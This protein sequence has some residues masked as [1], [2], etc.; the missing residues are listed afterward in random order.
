[1]ANPGVREAW[2][3]PARWTWLL[4]ALGAAAFVFSFPGASIWPLA[5]VTPAA[6]SAAAVTARRTRTL[7]IAALVTL[8]IAWGW[9]ERWVLDVSTLGWFP[10]TVTMALMTTV[11]LLALRR[12]ACHPRLAGVPLALLV[13]LTWCAGESLRGL[14][15]FD[16]YPWYHVAHPLIAA[17]ILVQSTDLF[18]VPGVSCLVA[19]PGGALLD[20]LRFRRGTTN[21]AV[22]IGAA[23]ATA[24]LWAANLG[25]GAWRLG[26]SAPLS[27]GPT[28]LAVQTNLPMSNKIAWSLE[29]QVDDFTTFRRQT[30]DAFD[31]AM[32]SGRRPDLVA[33]PETMLPGFGL[34][35]E[36]VQMLVQ[37]NYAPGDFFS[38]LIV[39][40]AEMLETPFL[41]GSPVYTGLRPEGKRWRWSAHFNSAYLVEPTG[42]LQ[43]YDKLFL[44]PFGERMPYFSSWPWLEERL[45]AIGASGMTF[46]LDAGAE[47]R[48]LD[49]AWRDDSGAV[50]TTRLATPICFEDTVGWLCRELVYERGVKSA[51]V[52]VNLS[53]DGWFGHVDAGREAHL[54]MARFRT[55]ELRVPMVRVVN[56]GITASIDSCGRLLKDDRL[57][58]RMSGAL[59]ATV[60]LDA[61]STLY[62]RIGDALGWVAMAVTAFLVLAA[63]RR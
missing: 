26:E 22:A 47:P 7:V 43:R 1:M 15:A 54:L 63:R 19:L 29:A 52:L 38:R 55:I 8:A 25:Y 36:T 4:C 2:S 49:L 16:G 21:R 35:P 10:L 62:S 17:P 11:A 48:R 33:W 27:T 46:D 20:W 58:P 51:G 50:R 30:L 28:V 37:G 41:V 34:E 14:L 12:I 23:T 40:M 42:R 18:G 61:R 45:L 5:F 44:T 39:D 57:A 56:T 60:T 32:S 24:L 13:P 31:E 6:Y 53:N 59:L 3:V 9:H